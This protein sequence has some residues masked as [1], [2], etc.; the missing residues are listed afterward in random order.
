MKIAVVCQEANRVWFPKEGNFQIKITLKMIS[1]GIK[2]YF[3]FILDIILGWRRF[4]MV[5]SSRW[6]LYKSQNFTN[7]YCVVSHYFDRHGI[8]K[9]VFTGFSCVRSETFK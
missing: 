8:F 6:K 5:C 9:Q 2:S 1:R 3:G 4:K 7:F